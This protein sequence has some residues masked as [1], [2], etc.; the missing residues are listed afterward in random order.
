VADAGRVAALTGNRADEQALTGLVEDALEVAGAQPADP[1]WPGVAPAVELAAADF[2]DTSTLEA[3]PGQRAELVSDF[4]SADRSYR[5]AGYCDTHTSEVGFANSAGHTGSYQGSRATIDGIHQSGESAGSAHQTSAALADI[6]GAS[7]G[8][9]AAE[10]ARRG[11]GAFDL[12]PGEYEVVLAPEAV[13]TI[14]MFLG[15]YGLNGKLHNEDQSFAEVGESQFDESISLSDDPL[16]A[17]A[18]GSS[19]DAEGTPKQSHVLVDRGTTSTIVHDRRSA[20]KAGEE[21]T[22]HG[23]SGSA[24]VGPVAAHLVVA[25][26]SASVEDMIGAVERGIYV[27]T[28]NYCRILDPKSQVVTGLTRNG[29]FMIENGAI[30]GAVTDLR[31][32]QSF[33][34]AWGPGRV[35][36]V[37]NDLRYA[38]CEFGAGLVRAPSMRLGSWNFTGGAA[39]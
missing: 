19:F 6:D 11:L 25:P 36:D 4:V 7:A 8:T 23:W 31:F 38:D 27:A 1:D 24:S 35:L 15:F 9:L 5:A 30:K 33:L 10:R 3:T 37:G 17:S 13:A 26:G 20:R 18:L 29:T 39:G 22:G 14:A 12:K 21:S 28:F 16:D 2:A 34:E 32:T